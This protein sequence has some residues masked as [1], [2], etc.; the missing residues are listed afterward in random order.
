M[1][2][3]HFQQSGLICG[4]L[5]HTSVVQGKLKGLL[6]AQVLKIA[7]IALQKDGIT[8]SCKEGKKD[9]MASYLRPTMSM[10]VY[11]IDVSCRL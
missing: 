9:K 3:A 6:E 4:R 2:V 5:F 7:I 1:E 8:I 10:N 11:E